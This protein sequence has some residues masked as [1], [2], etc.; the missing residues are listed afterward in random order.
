MS[1]ERALSKQKRYFS[2]LAR[3]ED[4]VEDLENGSNYDPVGLTRV[5]IRS[6]IDLLK[7]EQNL[8]ETLHFD[9]LELKA[10]SDD[11]EQISEF[12]RYLEKSRRIINQLIWKEQQL[13]E[14]REGSLPDRDVGEGSV[15]SMHR[16]EGPQV[17]LPPIELPSFRGDSDQWLPFKDTFCA[18]VQDNEFLTDVQKLHYLKSSLKGEALGLVSS[19]SSSGQNYNIAWTLL[20]D[21]YENKRLI[22]ND[23]LKAILEVPAV[24][25]QTSKGFSLLSNEVRKNLKAIEALGIS[26]EGWDPLLVYILSNKVDRDTQRDWETS[27]SSNVGM[28]SVQD[29]LDFLLKKGKVEQMLCSGK[30]EYFRQASNIGSN[31]D[32][33]RQGVVPQSKTMSVLNV[34]S[35]ARVI[36][37]V[38]TY[39]KK[40]GHS[41]QNCSK[42][43]SLPL[44]DRREFVETERLC[45]ICL[46]NQHISV[47]CKRGGCAV[48][49]NRH[50][51]LLHKYQIRKNRS[52]DNKVEFSGTST[53]EVPVQETPLQVGILTVGLPA[54][55]KVGSNDDT[56]HRVKYKGKH[57]THFLKG[58]STDYKVEG[59]TIQ[60]NGYRLAK[61]GQPQPQRH[62]I[63][64]ENFQ[65]VR[66]RSRPYSP[67]S[68][69]STY[70]IPNKYQKGWQSTVFDSLS[71][72]D[73]LQRL[74]WIFQDYQLSGKGWTEGNGKPMLE[75]P[76]PTFKGVNDRFSRHNW[77]DSLRS[78]GSV[79]RYLR[80]VPIV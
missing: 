56:S 34:T 19:L 15:A 17:K 22:I 38:C 28:P 46:S 68:S 80:K 30:A 16:R 29:L 45:Y 57:S 44:Q 65:E 12:D 5:S 48:C 71:M 25:P 14:N 60:G 50:N 54:H 72:S 55:G 58:P 47:S 70:H 21:H 32:G 67:H 61:G 4:F 10:N 13:L 53:G 63:G 79:N 24:G 39:C 75:R 33:S 78:H 6:N 66:L 77:S 51:V 49:K 73:R 41:I 18:L 64:K 1:L 59:K 23:H 2:S 37:S 69:P 20:R 40:G 8:F 3:V 76:F 31:R 43:S 7:E 9:I 27:I 62:T 74:E 52:S 36:Q 35:K 26:V 11:S 42:F